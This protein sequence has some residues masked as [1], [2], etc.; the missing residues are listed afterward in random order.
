VQRPTTNRPQDEQVTTPESF[1][2]EREVFRIVEQALELP[3]SGREDFIGREIARSRDQFGAAFMRRFDERTDDGGGPAESGAMRFAV[4]LL[5][6][7]EEMERR[8]VLD[9]CG[10]AGESSGEAS[11]VASRG[12]SVSLGPATV[13]LLAELDRI[14][15]TSAPRLAPGA[16]LSHF[17]I[18]R[19]VA[20]GGM[21]E[22]YEAEDRRVG[23]RVAIKVLPA[24]ASRERAQRFAREALL[25]ARVEHAAIARLY[26]WGVSTSAAGA[27]APLNFIAMEFIDGVALADATARLRAESPGDPRPIVELL[28]PIIDA[29][30][31][32]HARGVLHRDI[33][34]ANILVERGGRAR[35]LDFGVASLVEPDEQLALTMTGDS[36]KPG[37]LAYM[38]PEQVRGGRT[39][40]TTRSDVHALGLVLAE[41]LTGR[42]VVATEGRG[43]A[44]VVEQ[45]LSGEAPSIRAAIGGRRSSRWS[46]LD[47]IVRKALR[48]DPARRYASADALGEDLRSFLTGAP[49]GE[50]LATIDLLRRLAH[51]NRRA[52]AVSLGVLVAT[53]VAVGFGATQLIRAREAEARTEVIVGELLEGS[54][55]LVV[56]LHRRMLQEK[57]PLAARRAALEATVAYLEWVQENAGDDVRVLSE[58]ARRYLE[59]GQVAGSTGQGSLGESEAALDYFARSRAIL[60][61]LIPRSDVSDADESAM[62][63][64][65][66]RVLRGIGGILD[67]EERAGFLRLA[68]E[69]QRVA[70]ELLPPGPERDGAERFFL[71]TEIQAARVAWKLEGFAM[72]IERFRAMATE[73]R[74]TSDA[75]FMSEYGLAERYYADVL[76][77]RLHAAAGSP[78]EVREATER[79]AGADRG[80]EVSAAVD[81]RLVIEAMRNGQRAFEASIALGLDEFTNNRHLARI[82][83]MQAKFDATG[84]LNDGR[85]RPTLEATFEALAAVLARSRRATN[86]K[87]HDSFYRNSHCE[88][89]AL[90]ADAAIAAAGAELSRRA[91][92]G[93]A[94]VAAFAKRVLAVMEEE[95][96]FAQSLPTEGAP[97]SRES[98]L[99]EDVATLRAQ[100]EAIVSGD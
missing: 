66:S 68:T 79:V 83:L 24:F 42:A 18:R 40:V 93:R 61:A 62:R 29:V 2:A 94:D 12:T 89:V 17:T 100:L 92:D 56:D 69:D 50:E 77:A 28:L 84:L 65:R 14:A 98:L 47:F 45:V 53:G 19:F 27:D 58:I 64:V 96:A 23:R 26:E 74:F 85:P 95:L 52:I 51:R 39:R 6:R 30:A 44:E 20:A 54:R 81:P 63:L 87:P 76:E 99:L 46:D 82:A 25:M 60:D 37:T 16:T 67:I 4:R 75:E 3:E 91:N 41:S 10:T 70:V 48:K 5:R 36:A 49:L 1:H 97:H 88:M 72:P 15:E 71:T 34:P 7:T 35:L 22:V 57:Q 86:F 38:S 78:T 90:A 55:P 33:K 32:A 21:G 13:E 43:I 9:G 80:D 8:G 31:H 73:P 59:L 11:H